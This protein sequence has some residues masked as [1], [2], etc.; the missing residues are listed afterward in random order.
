MGFVANIIGGKLNLHNLVRSND[1]I[2]GFPHDVAGFAL[3]QRIL[4]GYLGVGVGKYTHSMSHAHIYDIHDDAA[5]AM[6]G[7]R[8]KSSKISRE[9]KKDW[10]KRAMRGDRELVIEIVSE[11]ERQYKPLAVIPGLKIVQ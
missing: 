4:A 5:K 8:A 1:M 6:M 7:R 10:L 3:L 11:L 2:L 9:P